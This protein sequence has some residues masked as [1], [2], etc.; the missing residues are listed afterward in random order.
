MATSKVHKEIHFVWKGIL[1]QLFFSISSLGNCEWAVEGPKPGGGEY[2]SCC[3]RF[4]HHHDWRETLAG[5]CSEG[6]PAEGA[7][8]GGSQK[9]WKSQFLKTQRPSI[10]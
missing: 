1:Q 8:K 5:E 7:Q 2:I 4:P 3:H 9:N 6:T 10:R